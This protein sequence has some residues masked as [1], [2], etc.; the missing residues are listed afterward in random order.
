MWL[1]LGLVSRFPRYYQRKWPFRSANVLTLSATVRVTNVPK[2]MRNADRKIP[3]RIIHASWVRN[4]LRLEWDLRIL[5]D[6]QLVASNFLEELRI[7]EHLNESVD[8]CV[9]RLLG[10]A[11]GQVDK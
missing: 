1:P 2:Q 8:R 4:L 7:V 3:I 10:D 9:A 11:D 6:A 5:Q